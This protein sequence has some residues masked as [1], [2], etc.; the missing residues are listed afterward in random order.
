MMPQSDKLI[1]SVYDIINRQDGEHN[2]I[3]VARIALLAAEYRANQLARQRMARAIE[4][5]SAA[6]REL[7]AS[8]GDGRDQQQRASTDEC[9][10]G[11]GP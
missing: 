3:E 5:R 6:R 7:R 1:E 8:S 10:R 4:R 2:R 11:D 9:L